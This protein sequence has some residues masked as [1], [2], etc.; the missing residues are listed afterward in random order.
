MRCAALVADG[1]PIPKMARGRAV[2]LTAIALA[3]SPVFGAALHLPAVAVAFTVLQTM[4]GIVL[5][6]MQGA[7]IGLHRFLA[8]GINQIIEG[9][10]RAGLGVWLGITWGLDGL[11]LAMFASTMVAIIILPRRQPVAVNLERPAT[12]LFHASLA[13]A[14]VGIFVQLDLLLAPSAFTV[15]QAT[16]YDLAAVPSKSVYL[17]LAALAPVLFPFVRRYSSRKLIIVGSGAT[18]VLGL[19]ASTALVL[20]RPVIAALLGQKEA[21]VENM[22]L[23]CVAMSLA[24]A[25]SMIVNSAIARGVIRPWPPTAVGMAALLLC[26]RFES[27]TAFA[28]S[29]VFIQL[30]VALASLG[31]V[32]FDKP[33][34]PE[35]TRLTAWTRQRLKRPQARP[36]LLVRDPTSPIDAEAPGW[37]R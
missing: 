32:Y 3:L 23:L 36:P 4:A 8:L 11:A 21:S 9:V 24:G 7:M 30:A 25:T 34:K 6:R 13:L 5:A 1:Q 10:A 37:E 20:L 27:V 15:A 33:G 28:V 35:Q 16:R 29:G 22:T 2:I 19:V 18:L 31:I 12:S 17:A 14:L 26:S